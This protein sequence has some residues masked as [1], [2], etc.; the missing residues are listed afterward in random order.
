MINGNKFYLQSLLS[1]RDTLFR[2][3]NRKLQNSNPSDK[4]MKMA[5]QQI[6]NGA[7]CEVLLF[8]RKLREQ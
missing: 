4:I 5:S 6:A 2:P 7:T 1:L 3:V 8:P